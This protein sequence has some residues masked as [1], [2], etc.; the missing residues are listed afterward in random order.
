MSPQFC[1]DLAGLTEAAL[2]ELNVEY[3]E[4][5]GTDRLVTMQCEVLPTENWNKFVR[6]RVARMGGSFEQFKLPCLIPDP[7]FSSVFLTEAGV[8]AKQDSSAK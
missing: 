5:R 3:H 6:T 7:E 2:R 4:K 8:F 1:A